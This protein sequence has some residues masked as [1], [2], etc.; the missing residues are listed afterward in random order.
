MAQLLAGCQPSMDQALLHP[1]QWECEPDSQHLQGAF[2]CFFLSDTWRQLK[3]GLWPS[4]WLLRAFAVLCVHMGWG[5]DCWLCWFPS[6]SGCVLCSDYFLWVLGIPQHIRFLSLTCVCCYTL[7]HTK[8]CVCMEHSAMTIGQSE[9]L[10]SKS[11]HHRK[12]MLASSSPG[13]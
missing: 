4:E 5:E 8:S 12:Q 9:E 6:P 13:M 3:S 11:A 7:E 10:N 2:D 1:Q